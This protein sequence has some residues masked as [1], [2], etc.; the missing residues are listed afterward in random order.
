MPDDPAQKAPEGSE[1]PGPGWASLVSRIQD[2]DQQSLEE[3]YRIFSKGIRFFLCRHLGP[4]ELED[5]V[6]DTFLIVVQ[7]IQRGEL[8]EPD[9]LMGFV[10]TI[11][12]RQI[13]SYIDVA[14]QTR[15]EQ[16]EFESGIAVIDCAA[17]PERDAIGREEEQL[18]RQI[19]NELSGRDREILVRFY[20]REQP[21]ELICEEMQ[22][23]ETQFRLLKSRAKAR[24]GE[25]GRRRLQTRGLA[26]FFVRKNPG[27]LHLLH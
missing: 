11:V 17:N 7:A 2:G 21:Q 19:L 4:Q 8:R 10:R 16:A 9:R 5:K 27:A 14:V 15:R 22:L 23:T 12:R 1:A 13:A 20:L 24:F 18:M 3:L 25:L 6:H 26:S